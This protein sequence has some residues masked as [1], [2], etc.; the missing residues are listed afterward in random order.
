MQVEFAKNFLD[1]F[2]AF[3]ENDEI[4]LEVADAAVF[5]D[6]HESALDDSEKT[7][8]SVGATNAAIAIGKQRKGEAIFFHEG[9][10]TFQRLRIDCENFDTEVFEDIEV[11]PV[12]AELRSTYFGVIA[13]IKNQKHRIFFEPFRENDGAFRGRQC[14]IGG[15][16]ADAKWLVH[17]NEILDPV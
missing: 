2:G 8:V 5:A 10:M 3:I 12:I 6:E 17:R 13:R 1:R 16:I 11:V 9:F 15:E 4:A 7:D 14:E